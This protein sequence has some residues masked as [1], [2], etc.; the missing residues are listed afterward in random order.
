MPSFVPDVECLSCFVLQ[1]RTKIRSL[2]EKRVAN[3]RSLTE[4]QRRYDHILQLAPAKE[5]VSV[6]RLWY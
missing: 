5:N 6:G 3:E 2:P 4:E 1:L